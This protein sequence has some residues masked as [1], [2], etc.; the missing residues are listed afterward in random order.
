MRLVPALFEGSLSWEDR[1]A[2]KRLDNI[3]R[4]KGICWND[5]LSEHE[6]TAKLST[7]TR[8]TAHAMFYLTVR[9]E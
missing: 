5:L 4:G 2:H 3:A 9:L 6:I 1:E 7:M 8:L